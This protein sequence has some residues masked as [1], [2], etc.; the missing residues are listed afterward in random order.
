MGRSNY[1]LLLALA[2]GRGEWGLLFCGAWPKRGK[3]LGFTV[4]LRPLFLLQAQQPLPT[5]TIL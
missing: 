2:N 3:G 4:R 1:G 5:T